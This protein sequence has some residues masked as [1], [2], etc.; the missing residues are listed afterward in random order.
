[1]EISSLDSRV[2]TIKHHKLKRLLHRLGVKSAILQ[3]WDH[4]ACTISTGHHPAITAEKHGVTTACG[5]LG[6]RRTWRTRK[7]GIYPMA[8]KHRENTIWL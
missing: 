4:V 7:W 2:T 3:R 8:V 5:H 1:M 6:V